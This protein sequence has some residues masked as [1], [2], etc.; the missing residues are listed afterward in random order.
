MKVKIV[1]QLPDEKGSNPKN[2]TIKTYYTIQRFEKLQLEKF[3][4]SRAGKVLSS[5]K[6]NSTE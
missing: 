5:R 4:V 1:N 2:A 6:R 3:E